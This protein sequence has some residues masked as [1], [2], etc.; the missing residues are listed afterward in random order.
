MRE[1]LQVDTRLLFMI[2]E[3]PKNNRIYGTEY[4]VWI[5]NY[6]FE[7]TTS[8]REKEINNFSVVW[9]ETILCGI[10]ISYC[11]CLNSKMLERLNMKPQS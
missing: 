8:G 6:H 4:T 1:H 10:H 5:W 3:K 11:S 9:N 7:S 2:Y